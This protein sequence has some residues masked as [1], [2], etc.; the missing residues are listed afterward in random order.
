MG[1]AIIGFFQNIFGNATYLV[2][3]IVSMIPLV[4]LKGGIL[5]MIFAPNGGNIWLSFLVGV[6]GS[7]II[8][9][10]L[11]LVFMPLINWMKKTKI[12][13]GIATWLENHF[14]KKSDDLEQK[15][16]QKSQAV[17]DEAE[18]KKRIERAKYFGLFVFTAIPLPLTGCWTASVVA[19]ILHLDYKK[20][21]LFIVLGNIVAGV[22]VTL[23]GGIL[24][25]PFF[26]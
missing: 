20:S 7:S 23:L 9:P 1:E 18:K 19:S 22:A 3:F 25:I 2:G 21:L 4:E 8:A 12:F 17:T 11:L 5:F 15:A 13:K 14:T 10:V 16:N 26:S 6:L 24:Q